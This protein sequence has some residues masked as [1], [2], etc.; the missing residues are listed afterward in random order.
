[1]FTTRNMVNNI[2][3]ATPEQLFF[4]YDAIL[5][6][7]CESDWAYIKERKY[8]IS[9]KNNYQ[10]N[11]IRIKHDNQ[12]NDKVLLQMQANYNYGTNVYTRPF[13]MTK[14]N[15]NGTVR[16]KNGMCH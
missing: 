8:K 14:F 7:R 2:N 13:Q 11:K 3:R 6:V 9:C 4:G 5:N 16:I 15:T 1:M 10:E 12:I